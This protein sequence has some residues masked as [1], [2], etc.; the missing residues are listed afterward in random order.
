ML[1]FVCSAADAVN[2][3]G[4]TVCVHVREGY[5]FYSLQAGC[6]TTTRQVGPE[7]AIRIPPSRV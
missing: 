3:L 7:G 1:S 4:G 5:I 2:G 6:V